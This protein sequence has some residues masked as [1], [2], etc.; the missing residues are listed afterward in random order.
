MIKTVSWVFI[1]NE[2]HRGRKTGMGESRTERIKKKKDIERR[3]GEEWKK[4]RRERFTL[5]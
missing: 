5:C 4:R 1:A 2:G 3:S